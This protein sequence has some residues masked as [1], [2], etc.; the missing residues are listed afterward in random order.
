MNPKKN[1]LGIGL[2]SS[3]EN[4]RN[5]FIMRVQY[6]LIGITRLKS[7]R[8][9]GFTEDSFSYYEIDVLHH[10]LYHLS[11]HFSNYFAV[12]SVLP[13]TYNSL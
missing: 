9:F 8:I 11:S 1:V 12:G 4:L 3:R 10:H 13:E 6:G 7:L 2:V 5:K